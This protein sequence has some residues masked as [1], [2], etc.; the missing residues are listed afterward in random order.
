MVWE[1]VCVVLFDVGEVAED[2]V[3][4]EKADLDKDLHVTAESQDEVQAGL[5]LNV[6]IRVNVLQVQR[7]ANLSLDLSLYVFDGHNYKF[8]D[9]AGEGHDFRVVKEESDFCLKVQI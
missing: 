8:E 4:N 1:L 6:V 5:I 7:C 9:L 2:K 3:Q